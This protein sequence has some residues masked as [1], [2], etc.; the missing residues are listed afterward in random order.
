[1]VTP[2]GIVSGTPAGGVLIDGNPDAVVGIGAAG[3]D[4]FESVDGPQGGLS[5]PQR[6]L[7]NNPDTTYHV[8]YRDG[9]PTQQPLCT[10][11]DDE[12]YGASGGQLSSVVHNTDEANALTYGGGT[13]VNLFHQREIYYEA[14]GGADGVRRLEEMEAPLALSLEPISLPE[15]SGEFAMLFAVPALAWL[16]WRRRRGPPLPVPGEV[17]LH[18]VQ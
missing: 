2:T 1:V 6:L 7:T 17:Q 16:N 5:M 11:D 14:P 8:V 15:P 4:A 3:L 13:F 12:L 10:G 18:A 9:N